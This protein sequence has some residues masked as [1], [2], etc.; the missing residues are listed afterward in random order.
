MGSATAAGPPA[1]MR[2]V[3]L[4]GGRR[5]ELREVPVPVPG[6]GQVL[7][8][9]R[10][11]SI[12][13]SDLRA[14][15]REHLGRGAEAYTGVIAGHEPAGA[16]VA[17]G[18]GVERFG[19]G[20]RVAIYHIAGCGV[21]PECRSGSMVACSGR[22]RAAHGWQR[23]GGHAPYMVAEERTLVPLPEP[24]TFADGACVACGFGTAYE[25]LCRLGVGGRDRV[26]VT[27]L[28]PVGL[29]VGMLAR[30]LGA[31]EVLG[32][33]TSE[34]RRALAVELGV[35]DEAHPPEALAADAGAI[36]ADVAV[37]CSGAAAA[38]VLALD[39]L[40]RFGRCAFVGEGGDVTIDVSRQLIHKDIT[41]L[42]SWVTSVARMEE[43]TGLLARTGVHPDR[44]VTHRFG[45][46]QAAEAYA[47]ADA[48]AAGK[49]VI[50]P[51]ASGE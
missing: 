7:V 15:Y 9:V 34:A 30:L 12:C 23:D 48:Q 22:S 2:G 40:R 29:A 25:A 26:L 13:G 28:G 27:G 4:P 45:L 21:C 3:V 50:E 35:V 39:G 49:V 8:E 5:V 10:A 42:G 44:T 24:L 20:D 33:E 17:A 11:S 36:G 43:L 31:R 38:R 19:P 46:E 18:P 32:A 41:L 6:H 47:T 14:I 1:T 16:V 51:A 37:D